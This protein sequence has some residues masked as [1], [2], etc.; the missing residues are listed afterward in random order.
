MRRYVYCFVVLVFFLNLGMGFSSA[1]NVKVLKIANISA[2][3]GQA[4]SWGV[5][6][7]RA[8]HMASEDVGTFTVGGQSYKWEVV[9]YDH[10]YNPATAVSALNRAIFTDGIRYGWI[11]GSGV[12][13][14]LLPLLKENYFLDFGMMGA[15]KNLTNPDNPTVFRSM[16]SSD[17]ILMTF[18]EDIYKIYKVDSIGVIVPNDEMGRSD[19]EIWRNLHR[20]KKPDIK[21]LGEEYYERGT[22][23]FYPALKR[24][25]VKKPGMLFTNAAPTGTIAL[26]AKQARELGFNGIINDATSVL[27]ADVLWNTAGKASDGILAARMWPEPP[28]RTYVELERRYKEKYKEEMVSLFPEAYAAIPWI[29]E[30]IRKANSIDT[31]KVVPA[32][33][34]TVYK[35]HPFG[36]A[37]WGGERFYGIKRQIEY[38]IPLSITENGKWKKVVIKQGKLD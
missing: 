19:A 25:L 31:K 29:T 3:S 12:H 30:A 8:L 20:E 5:G 16:A 10:G 32:L 28:T 33:A 9:D 14:A 13:P 23:D 37:S 1:E 4:A 6:G 35:N 7:S 36:L 34:D 24:I 27:E 11:Q 18:F 15:G 17:E 38:P 26:I 21:I 22:T 2:M